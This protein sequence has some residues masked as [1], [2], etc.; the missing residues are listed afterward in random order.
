MSR[1]HEYGLTI[2]WSAVQIFSSLNLAIEVTTRP[3]TKEEIPQI[4]T[5]E[6]E[7]VETIRNLVRPDFILI[8]TKCSH[9]LGTDKGALYKYDPSHSVFRMVELTTSSG[10]IKL[11]EVIASG[12]KMFC[13][14]KSKM[15]AF[16]IDENLKIEHLQNLIPNYKYVVHPDRPNIIIRFSDETQEEVRDLDLTRDHGDEWYLKYRTFRKLDLIPNSLK[17]IFINQ[18][19]EFHVFNIVTRHNYILA[20]LVSDYKISGNHILVMRLIDGIKYILSIIDAENETHNPA[21]FPTLLNIKEVKLFQYAVGNY[22][23][24]LV[25]E[26][27]N[28]CLWTTS[29][30]SFHFVQKLCFNVPTSILL[31]S[32]FYIDKRVEWLMYTNLPTNENQFV[33]HRTIDEGRFWDVV[34]LKSKNVNILQSIKFNFE[35][36]QP[37]SIPEHFDWFDFQYEKLNDGLQ[38]Y[39]TFDGGFSWNPTPKSASRLLMLN[40]E[41]V[42]ISIG[43]EFSAINFSFDKGSTWLSHNLFP[44]QSKLHHFEKLYDSDLKVL[45]VTRNS[46]CTD[47]RID[48]LDFSNIFKSECQI[49]QFHKV[50]LPKPR[51]ICYQGQNIDIIT[52]DPDIICINKIRPYLSVKSLCPCSS[53]D[54]VCDFNFQFKDGICVLDPLYNIPEMP[55]KCEKE[56]DNNIERFGYIKLPHDKCYPHEINLCYNVSANVPC[57]QREIT[58]FIILRSSQKIF[59]SQIRV[60]G[61]HFPRQH[62]IEVALNHKANVNQPFTFDN[63]RQHLY[64]YMDNYIVRFQWDGR[65]IQVLYFQNHTIID[66]VYDPIS[67]V[68][69]Y[70]TNRQQLKILSLLT[71]YE[72]VISDDVMG[73]TYSSHHR[74]L[75]MVM[76][77][78]H[79]CYWKWLGSPVCIKST[80][81]LL[82]SFVDFQNSRVYLLTTTKNLIIQLF[83]ND[84]SNLQ[85]FDE[86]Q[87]VNQFVVYDDNLYYLTKGQLMYLDLKEKYHHTFL[88]RDAIFN[89]L[90]LHRGSFANYK[91]IC[92]SLKCPYFCHLSSNDEVICG[93]PYPMALVNNKCLCPKDH[94]NCKMPICVGFRCEN[95]KCLLNNVRCN[96]VN[97]CGDNSDEI[98]CERICS[99]ETHLCRN[100]CFDKDAVCG[101]LDITVINPMAGSE[102]MLT[103]YILLITC[104]CIVL[105]RGPFYLA[106]KWFCGK[107]LR[108][109]NRLDSNNPDFASGNDEIVE[110]EN[111][112]AEEC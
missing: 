58:N 104:A 87:E 65:Y 62:A 110:V 74:L 56:F 109:V 33:T 61:G 46:E 31:E 80:F 77:T 53:N 21:F 37:S 63:L 30:T 18:D 92:E 57:Q 23:L 3:A 52:R 82:Q 72:H 106:F 39:M 41:T 26:D 89:S 32:N 38:P 68:L 101:P 81:D 102:M 15:V 45:I 90:S 97:D 107:C 95:S 8:L 49:H 73:F 50:P 100:K 36:H 96:G 10:I 93:C 103:F 29:P 42:I 94:T 70:L 60:N 79:F 76:S 22:Y 5:D 27:L 55:I 67:H 20:Y 69:I 13:I 2:L 66:L 11:D 85:P 35:L 6:C 7:Q 86:I 17:F 78:N 88:I 47:L 75:S 44:T 24:V 64:N 91:S 12:D 1:L 51:G 19:N 43:H 28:T 98:N 14:S 84:P 59:I 40:S 16:F 34:N 9:V 4:L 25:D 54:F 108:K 105:L 83:V 48:I 71:N 112:S 99:S 111:H